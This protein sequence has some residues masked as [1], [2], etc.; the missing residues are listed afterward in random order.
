MEQAKW[1][2]DLQR[3]VDGF[4]CCGGNTD[5]M[6]VKIYETGSISVLK[7]KVIQYNMDA[8][9]NFLQ[10]PNEKLQWPAVGLQLASC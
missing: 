4:G 5:I 6:S 9:L 10:W 1:L 3:L 2:A 7:R 8:Y